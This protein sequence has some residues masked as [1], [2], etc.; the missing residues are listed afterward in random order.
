[1]AGILER[2]FLSFG[3]QVITLLECA[4]IYGN[5]LDGGS[6]LTRIQCSVVELTS[7]LFSSAYHRLNLTGSDLYDNHG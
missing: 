3:C 5:R 2:E 7:L 1:M 6:G 4:R